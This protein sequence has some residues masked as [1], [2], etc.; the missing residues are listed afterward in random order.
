MTENR[1][2]WTFILVSVILILLII[3][4]IDFLPWWAFVIPIMIFGFLITYKNTRF[5][6]FATGFIAGFLVWCL[7]NIYFDISGSGLMLKRMADLLFIHKIVFLFISG[8]VGG[9][10]AGLSLY[11]G[12]AIRQAFKSCARD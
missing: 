1:K 11:T 6:A 4:R 10:M 9:T 3:G 12:K 8:L 7:G 2:N 5:P